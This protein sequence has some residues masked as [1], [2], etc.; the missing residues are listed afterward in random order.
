MKYSEI[1]DAVEFSLEYGPRLK[2]YAYLKAEDKLIA[3]TDLP[4]DENVR[5][6]AIYY[7]KENIFKNLAARC[8]TVV[9]RTVC[10]CKRIEEPIDR[11]Q[12]EFRVP[13][14]PRRSFELFSFDQKPEK[15]LMNLREFKFNGRYDKDTG[16]RLFEEVFG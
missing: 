7:F 15:D 3:E 4:I 1:K 8:K 12:T 16:L 9:L 11:R 10:G 5:E 13:L 6:E 2:M 14:P